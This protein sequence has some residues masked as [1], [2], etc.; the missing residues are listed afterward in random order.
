MQKTPVID[1]TPFTHSYLRHLRLGQP[2][3]DDMPDFRNSA[4][5]LKYLTLPT[6]ETLFIS[7]FDILAHHFISFLA[8]SSP[9]LQS[10]H[11]MPEDEGNI[12]DGWFRLLPTLTDLLLAICR[13]PRAVLEM[14]IGQDC[15]SNLRNLTIYDWCS[16]IDSF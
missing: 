16:R 5:I 11:V 7:H 9:P 13:E 8:R 6:L 2:R 14:A 12:E 10:L 15:L 3:V 1:L 4:Q